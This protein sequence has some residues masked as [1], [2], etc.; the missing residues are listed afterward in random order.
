MILNNVFLIL[1]TFLPLLLNL[2]P[3]NSFYCIPISISLLGVVQKF[4]IVCPNFTFFLLLFRS[5]A[6]L[7]GSFI[8]LFHSLSLPL[9]FSPP[10][11]D[12]C[13]LPLLHPLL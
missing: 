12:T 1:R 6:P 5:S 4:Y 2:I 11:P 3:L 7:R 9:S 8:H 13:R 10:L